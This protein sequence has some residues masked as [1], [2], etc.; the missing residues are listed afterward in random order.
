MRRAGFDGGDGADGTFASVCDMSDEN[1][2]PS[3][4]T[5]A[6]RAFADSPEPATNAASSKT[7]LFIGV[8]LAAILVLALA[9]WLALG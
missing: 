9:I 1:V 8:A 2:D 7:P 3:G 6:F 4:N 5:A